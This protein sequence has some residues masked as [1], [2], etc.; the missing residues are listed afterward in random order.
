MYKKQRKEGVGTDLKPS[1][2][3]LEI[4]LFL[5]IDYN[6]RLKT[7]CF[8][9]YLSFSGTRPWQSL[10]RSITV[11]PSDSNQ[12][13]SNLNQTTTST[14]ISN[15]IHSPLQIP[16]STGGTPA[17]ARRISVFSQLFLDTRWTKM[18][19]C[20]RAHSFFENKWW[21][22]CIYIYIYKCT[23]VYDQICVQLA[24]CT[25]CVYV[26]QPFSAT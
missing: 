5:Y 16:I 23:T 21:K 13:K 6:V 14:E 10:L 15:N 24:V 12:H 20:R 8:K 11:S 25:T 19:S 9:D 4:D 7:A 17:I 1:T 2:L 18:G 26:L 22:L 3:E